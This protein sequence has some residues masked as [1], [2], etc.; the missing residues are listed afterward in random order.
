MAL[1]RFLSWSTEKS[2]PIFQRL[3]KAERFRWSNECEVAFQ[4]LKMML[5]SP[6][7]L[8]RPVLGQLY[9]Y[10]FSFPM[11]RCLGETKA[12]RAIKEVHEGACGSHID[13]RAL[14]S[15]IVRARF[16]WPTIKKDS[17]TFV[18]NLKRQKD[19]GELPQVLWSYH[20]I[21]HL[22]TQETRFRL[23]FGTN[24]MIPV[25]VEESSPCIVFTQ[26]DCNEEEMRENLDLL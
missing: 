12:E 7:I 20:T 23:T 18:K 14:A 22:T 1:A 17:L 9:G 5:A 13:G 24:T 11:L 3:R 26:C 25:E 10:G 4:E 16:Y 21:P 19:D 6:P 8:T 2:A 15:K